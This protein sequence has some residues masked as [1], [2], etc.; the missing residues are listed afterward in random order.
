[1]CRRWTGGPAPAIE[2]TGVSFGGDLAPA[3][4]ASSAWAERGFCP[5][6]GSNLFYRLIAADRYMMWQG[7]FDDQSAFIVEAEIFIDEKPPGYALAGDHS[8]MTGAEFMA[9]L[10]DA[11]D[12]PPGD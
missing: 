7:A 12:V 5:R 6:C 10:A 2:V 4:H 3:R 8:R 9:S 1:M 11:A